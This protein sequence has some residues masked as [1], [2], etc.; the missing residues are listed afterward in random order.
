MH[1]TCLANAYSLGQVWEL[2]RGL[3]VAAAEELEVEVPAE[4]RE[5]PRAVETA[6]DLR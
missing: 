2:W 5:V 4:A 6:E 3:E 1:H